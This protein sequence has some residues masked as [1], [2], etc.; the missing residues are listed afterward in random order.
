MVQMGVT[1]HPLY[2]VWKT[3]KSRCLNPKAS[4]FKN[5]GGRGITVC[6]AWQESFETFL[7]DVGERPTTKHSLERRKNDLGYQPGNVVWATRMERARN[8]RNNTLIT[9]NGLTM[10]LTEWAEKIGMNRS[11]LMSRVKKWGVAQALT[12]EKLTHRKGIAVNIVS[13]EQNVT[14]FVTEC[15]RHCHARVS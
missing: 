5:Y 8:R 2:G 14:A 6:M 13:E 9:H 7:K 4:S 10:T 12:V 15:F 3:M 1:N 11:A